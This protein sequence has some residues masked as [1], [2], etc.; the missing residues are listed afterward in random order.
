MGRLVSNDHFYLANEDAQNEPY[1]YKVCGL[2][3]IY[4]LNGFVVEDYHGELAVAVKDVDGLHKAIGRHIVI[5]RKGLSPQEIRFL[6]KTLDMTQA[7]LGKKLGCD[8]QSVARW[9][10][11]T[12]VMPA[13]TEKLLRAIFFSENIRSDDELP[14]LKRMI[15]SAL[16][17]LDEMDDWEPEQAQ[18]HFG[19][20]WEETERRAA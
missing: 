13:P 14:L 6:R 10:K 1:H 17:E 12:C 11:G 16:S 4:L 7:D 18:F 15:D 5:H 2:D 3:N 19:N 9:E 20:R 8:S